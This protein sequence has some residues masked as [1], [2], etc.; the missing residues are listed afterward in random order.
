MTT[1]DV[2][3]PIYDGLEDVQRCLSSVFAAT[4]TRKVEY[5][6]I[7]DAGPNEK[8]RDY[9]ASFEGRDQVTVLYNTENLG[10]VRT[11]N[12]GMALHPDRDVILLNSDTVVANDWVDRLHS[13]AYSAEAEA[14]PQH[15]ESIGTVTPFSNNAEICSFPRLCVDNSLPAACSASGLDQALASALGTVTVDLPTA[16]G[17]CMYIRRDCLEDVGPFDAET[18]GLGY[19]EENDFCQRAIAK[20]WRHVLAAGCFVEHR[21]G[22]SFSSRKQAL[23]AKAM[24]ILNRRYPSYHANVAKWIADDPAYALR[25]AG[26]IEVLR[27][28]ARIKVLALTHQLGGG[29]E[30]HVRELSDAT[31]AKA[32]LL[33]LRP[34]KDSVMRLSL[35]IEDSIPGLNFDWS[36]AKARDDLLLLLRH[37]GVSRLHV[38]HVIGL[39]DVLP[40]LIA[41]LDLPYDVT[42]HDFYLID[43]NPT[44]TDEDGLFQAR[45]SARGRGCNSAQV[46]AS[47]A[48][49]AQWQTRQGALLKGAKRV[50]SPSAAALALYRAVYPL[51]QA[52]VVGHTDL[53]GVQSLPVHAAPA[54]PDAPF[55][56]LVLGAL[57][58]EKG[59]VLL[60]QVAQAAERAGY[61]WRF[62]LLGYAFRP[63]RNV[64]VLGAYADERLDDLIAAQSAQLIW[65]PCRWPETYSYTLSAALRSGLPLL[66]PDIGS[67]P[68]RVVG[69]PLTWQSA[70][71]GDAAHYLQL[72][73]TICTELNS[74]AAETVAWAP[75]RLGDFCYDDAYAVTTTRVSQEASVFGLAQVQQ[76]LAS[77]DQTRRQDIRLALLRVLLWLKRRPLL[78]W[79]M[80]R[81]PLRWQRA[82]KR[83]L[84]RQPLHEIEGG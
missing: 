57:G 26:M 68:E 38:H 77:P 21:G 44:L 63:L 18:F 79:L 34:F 61:N 14:A 17:F 10:F 51:D 33:V 41:E 40:G 81:I 1:V 31:D 80:R 45:R 35:G 2:I 32:C 70:Y 43:G 13:C 47:E 39:E 53:L 30:K 23:V 83:R 36:D 42:L 7:Y 19:G 29:T 37:L 67:F 78:A 8:L 82:L 54:D 73:D 74:S 22:V 84:S 72:L 12:R 55:H 50:F 3:V 28:D 56:I 69:R 24:D 46:L 65:F 58:V 52:M 16:V 59:A 60:E 15:E 20:G 49:L 66:V 5:T 64:E 4:Q 76:Y 9:V 6:L 71:D 11:V 62:S 25:C 27:R 48:E 75:P